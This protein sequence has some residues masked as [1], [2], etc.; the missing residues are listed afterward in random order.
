MG[1]GRRV[2]IAT[3]GLMLA[4]AVAGEALLRMAPV[5]YGV[6]LYTNDPQR[7]W[8]LRGGAH[9]WV[10]EEAKQYVRI[11]RDGF[12]DR[13]RRMEKPAHT[14][15]IAVLGNS[16]T[17]ALQVP[18]E[19]TFCAVME[20]ELARCAAASDNRVEVLNFGTSG[21]SSAQELLTL[22][23]EVC[24][25][26]NRPPTSSIVTALGSSHQFLCASEQEH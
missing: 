15:R 11:N 23:L 6:S 17:E 14:T 20:R 25:D 1:A 24:A 22:R 19:S 3:G 10:V 9:G 7:G 13:E 21:Y 18:L 4:L 12:R 2:L 26:S 8:A 5:E 16:W